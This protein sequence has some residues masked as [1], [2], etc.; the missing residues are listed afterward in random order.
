MEI[1]IK[2]ECKMGWNETT[3]TDVM[4]M[5]RRT[6]AL[7]L[8]EIGLTHAEGKA[9][10]KA[11]QQEIV[12]QQIHEYSTFFRICPRCLRMR[13]RK[14]TRRRKL[15]TVFG[16]VAINAPRHFV[17]ECEHWIP[18]V[19]TPVSDLLSA[20]KTPELVYLQA[21]LASRMPYR[22]AA[23]M[24]EMFLP[25][26]GPVSHETIRRRTLEVGRHFEARQ[27]ESAPPAPGEQL[28]VAYIGMDGA[29]V[30]ARPGFNRRNHEI[31]VGRL[32]DGNKP[33]RV[34]TALR[35]AQQLATDRIQAA[36]NEAGIGP[37]TA[38]TIFSDGDDTLAGLVETAH[39][40]PV[41]RI[42]DWYHIVMRFQNIAK[43]I[44]DL[45]RLDLEDR[46]TIEAG[47][48]ELRHLRWRIWH[49]QVERFADGA[50]EVMR[51]LDVFDRDEP[52]W[53][54]DRLRSVR[55]RLDELLRYLDSN[56]DALVDYGARYRAGERISTGFVESTVNSLV[57]HRMGKKR[58]MRWTANGAHRLLQVR[59]A[60][61]NGE[62]KAHFQALH[63]AFLAA[64][65][66][67]EGRPKPQD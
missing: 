1:T 46:L 36:L 43:D 48:E 28:D 33:G 27:A 50:D 9:M 39:G 53:S 3:S 19:L 63:P 17:C 34:F 40:K 51:A 58:Q 38:I 23:E 13:R 64:D 24:L 32:L 25:T 44:G 16:Q 5:T 10:L 30:R 65:E 60:V 49:R 21:Q 7:E 18:F 59:V 22:K 67:L 62:L 12:K 29:H 57:N 8:A 31:I 2:V 55:Y 14:D 4:T 26:D 15:D 61:A 45:P 11:V 66:R 56:V 20:R 42:L 52:H 47:L 54:R 41:S 35:N 6:A 37:D